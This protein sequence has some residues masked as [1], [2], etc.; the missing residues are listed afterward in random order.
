[1]SNNMITTRRYELDWLRVIAFGVLIYFHAAI[2]FIPFGL[3]LIQ[4][5]ETSIVLE[6]FV[7]ISSQFRLAL[8]FFISGVGVYF[9]RRKLTERGF[10]EERSRRLLIPFIVGLLFV[11]PPMVYTEKVFLGEFQGSLLEFYPLVVTTGVY[12]QGNLSWHHFWFIAYLYLFCLLAITPFRWLSKLDAAARERLLSRFAGPGLYG[13]IPILFVAEVL[14]RWLFP[15]F[16]DL[17]HDW[18]SF[19]QWFIVFLAGYCIA[20]RVSL[21]D[22]AVRFRRLS[23]LLA[24]ASTVT[25]YVLFG[26]PEPDLLSFENPLGNYVL[27]CA[28]RMTMVWCSILTCLGY[29]GRYLRFSNGVLSYL[30]EA[31]YPLFILHLTTLVVFGYFIVG[32]DWSVGVKYLVLTTSTI[33]FVLCVYQVAIKPFDVMRLLFGVKPKAPEGD[34]VAA[35]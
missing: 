31:V 13:L 9:A 28:L 4:N 1:M 14:L 26:E 3:P 2:F 7:H 29:A 34:V 32:F 20:I 5:E 23:L 16:R 8:L 17:I 24:V 19:T 35:G 12:P 18:A 25:L 30:N 10:I 22:D 15:G 6:H 21:I 11:V 27:W 33:A